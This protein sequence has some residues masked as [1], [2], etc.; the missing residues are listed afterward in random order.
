MKWW[1]WQ[2]WEEYRLPVLLYRPKRKHLNSCCNL[3]SNTD[4]LG[5]FCVLWRELWWL[6]TNV[7][8]K[9]LDLVSPR[10][11]NKMR[12]RVMQDTCDPKTDWTT[13]EETFLL[14]LVDCHSR[15]ARD[16]PGTRRDHPGLP[17][18]N[19]ARVNGLF[20]EGI[21]SIMIKKTCW[22]QFRIQHCVKET[23]QQIITVSSFL[24]KQRHYNACSCKHNNPNQFHLTASSFQGSL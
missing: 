10:L 2:H 4:L 7:K 22:L 5:A 18:V 6:I 19:H 8:N 24:C 14:Y 12:K 17:A 23:R 13:G 3:K 21:L 16:K 1:R 11:P 9:L 15:L 20:L